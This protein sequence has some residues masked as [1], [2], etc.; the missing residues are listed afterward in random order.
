MGDGPRNPTIHE[1]GCVV[2]PQNRYCPTCQKYFEIEPTSKRLKIGDRLKDA[3][4]KGIA[5]IG[6]SMTV[7]QVSVIFD[8]IIR[9]IK[10]AVDTTEITVE[11]TG[12]HK[13]D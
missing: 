6:D 11:I 10:D 7:V 8:G 3:G 12:L 2:G 5:H 9:E 1:G 4:P 13:D